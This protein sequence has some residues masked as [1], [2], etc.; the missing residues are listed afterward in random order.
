MLLGRPLGDGRIRSAQAAGGRIQRDG[1]PRRSLLRVYRRRTAKIHLCMGPFPVLQGSGTRWVKS[2][3]N[4]QKSG[5]FALMWGDVGQ[6]RIARLFR[7]RSGIRDAQGLTT[8]FS[9]KLFSGL[10]VLEHPG[11][12][13]PSIST[14]NGRVRSDGRSTTTSVPTP[15]SLDILTV[16]P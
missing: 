15:S 5:S 16:P 13:F 2:F 11:T 4:C 9:S 1:H 7:G 3:W 12:T 8:D 10:F 6:E 14:S